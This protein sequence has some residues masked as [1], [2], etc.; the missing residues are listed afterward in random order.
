MYE[1]DTT[2]TPWA[3]IQLAQTDDYSLQGPDIDNWINLAF[4]PAYSIFPGPHAISIGG[5]A[6]PLD[7]FG[8][9]TS[10]DAEVLMSR[11]QDNGCNLGTQH[12]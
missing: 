3:F 11:I 10:G 7:T 2:Q 12:F 9:S 1:V 4:K 5:Y 8:V 6:H